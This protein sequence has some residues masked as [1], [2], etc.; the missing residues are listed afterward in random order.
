MNTWCVII[1]FYRYDSRY[2]FLYTRYLFFLL[3]VEII[4]KAWSRRL[5]PER[6][7]NYLV[8]IGR[9]SFKNIQWILLAVYVCKSYLNI[10]MFAYIYIL[11]VYILFLF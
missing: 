4:S 3:R 2:Y 7:K 9:T 5:N 8:P 1:G 10:I 11:L 6:N